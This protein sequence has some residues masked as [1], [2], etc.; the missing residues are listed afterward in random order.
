MKQKSVEEEIVTYSKALA[1]LCKKARVKTPDRLIGK[2]ITM[3]IGDKDGRYFAMSYGSILRVTIE[4]TEGDPFGTGLFIKVDTKILR[5][6]PEKKS[7]FRA[8]S[9]PKI[10]PVDRGLPITIFF[11]RRIF[12]LFS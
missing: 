7:W 12:S 9:N 2:K 4:V 11:P 6:D 5:Y 3:I 10:I 1:D 8:E